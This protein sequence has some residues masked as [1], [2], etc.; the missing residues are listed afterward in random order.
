MAIS[1]EKIRHKD[2]RSFTNQYKKMP[3]VLSVCVTA[4]AAYG[5]HRGWNG[6]LFTDSKKY[7]VKLYSER[8]VYATSQAFFAP[9]LMPMCA[10]GCLVRTEKKIR[11]IEIEDVDWIW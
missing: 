9:L 6:R 11:N 3:L 10:Y 2:E 4:S 8:M 7:D 5:F 1:Y